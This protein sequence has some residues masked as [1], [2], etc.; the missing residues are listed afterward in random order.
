METIKSCLPSVED[1]LARGPSV[2]VSP[3]GRADTQV[4]SPL[5][6]P[7]QYTVSE[8]ELLTS[9]LPASAQMYAAS[10]THSQWGARKY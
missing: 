3:E 9:H 8:A 4:F 6:P 1:R 7:P 10:L 2:V 5:A